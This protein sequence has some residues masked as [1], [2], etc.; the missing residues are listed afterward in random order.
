MDLHEGGSTEASGSQ[1]LSVAPQLV[2]G[3]VHGTLFFFLQSLGN[4]PTLS[5]ERDLGG[6][7]L[8]FPSFL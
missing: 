2:A 5:G 6:L 8:N 7:T 3:Q 4:Y 1:D